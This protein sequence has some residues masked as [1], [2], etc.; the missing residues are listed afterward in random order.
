MS[1]KVKL[2]SSSTCRSSP[3]WSFTSRLKDS[4]DEGAPGPGKYG[5]P[6]VQEKYRSSPSCS[7]GTSVRE[8]NKKFAG[9][10][11][12]GTHTPFDPNLTSPMWGFGSAARIPKTKDTG[13]PAPGKYKLPGAIQTRNMTMGG[14]HAGRQKRSSSM[15]GPGAYMPSYDQV[16]SCPG[17]VSMGSE[18]REKASFTKTS[19]DAPG[20]GNYKAMEELGGNIVTR[21]CPNFTMSSRRRPAK[22]DATPGPCLTVYSQF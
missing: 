15:P 20:P 4:S 2:H 13:A 19:S 9:L 16:E 10:P 17:R 14:R 11:G 21:S 18:S 8:T 1:L 7:F 12:P 22:S 3:Q 6:S 5:A